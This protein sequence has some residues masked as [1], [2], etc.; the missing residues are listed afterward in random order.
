MSS[1]VEARALRLALDTISSALTV[2]RDNER[3]RAEVYEAASSAASGATGRS[4]AL[5]VHEREAELER[6][7]R[8]LIGVQAAV[9]SALRVQGPP[10]YEPSMST[11]PTV[12][13]RILRFFTELTDS[14]V[15]DGATSVPIVV[16][17][18]MVSSLTKLYDALSYTGVLT[19]T[20]EERRRRVESHTQAQRE[21]LAHLR[22]AMARGES[23]RARP[24]GLDAPGE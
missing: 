3:L 12:V 18:K 21:I 9:V 16:L 5:R 19:E 1:D 6:K 22:A 23:G 2:E 20:D 7:Q 10:S 15:S 17:F 24:A 8:E 11:L 13:G 4:L 14:A